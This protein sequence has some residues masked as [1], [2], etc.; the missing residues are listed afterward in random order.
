MGCLR[1]SGRLSGWYPPPPPRRLAQQVPATPR[2][3][4]REARGD[5]L[6]LLPRLDLAPPGGQGRRAGRG[7]LEGL[8][9][10]A[11]DRPL[12]GPARAAEDT[13]TDHRRLPPDDQLKTCRVETAGGPRR[14][15]A[16]KAIR[17]RGLHYRAKDKGKGEREH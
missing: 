11:E 12:R 9:P 5:P 2:D 13:H 15:A 16:S 14:P 6:R 10:Q 1:L 4:R 17:E 3:P 8:L 7:A